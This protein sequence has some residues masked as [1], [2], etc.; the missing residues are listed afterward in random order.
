MESHFVD[1]QEINEQDED[2]TEEEPADET[3]TLDCKGRDALREAVKAIRPI[4]AKLPEKDRKKAADAL[5]A[6]MRKVAGLDAKAARNDYLKLKQAARKKA[7]DSSA[8][9]DSSDL[10]ERIMEKRNSNYKK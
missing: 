8:E 3:G 6:Q 9:P 10:A 7:A 4:I 1:P 5:S 2:E